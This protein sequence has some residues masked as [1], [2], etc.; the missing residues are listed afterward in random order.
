MVSWMSQEDDWTM[1]GDASD[2]YNSDISSVEWQCGPTET[3]HDVY[4]LIIQGFE[5]DGQAY[6]P[7][8]VGRPGGQCDYCGH[9]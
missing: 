1:D 9:Y 8:T 7:Q 6:S 5:V 4:G 3:A 2:V